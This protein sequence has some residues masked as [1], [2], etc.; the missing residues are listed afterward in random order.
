MRL[1]LPY[2][3][4]AALDERLKDRPRRRSRHK[5]PTQRNLEQE[6]FTSLLECKFKRLRRIN[7]RFD[8]IARYFL[9]AVLP[10]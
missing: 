9:S 3:N 6:P 8:I 1:I 4:T 7:A 10:A 5:I 2:C